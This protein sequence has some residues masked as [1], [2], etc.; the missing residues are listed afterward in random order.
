VLISGE[1]YPL[2]ETRV[3]LEE[4]VW[5]EPFAE[6][7]SSIPRSL[8]QN[9]TYYADQYRVDGIVWRLVRRVHS[10]PSKSVL[11]CFRD[12]EF[13]SAVDFRVDDLVTQGTFAS[14]KPLSFFEFRTSFR[15]WLIVHALPLGMLPPAFFGS[16]LPPHPMFY[17]IMY[18]TCRFSGDPDFDYHVLLAEYSIVHPLIQVATLDF[19]WTKYLLFRSAVI[20]AHWARLL[21]VLRF[22]A[23]LRARVEDRRAYAP[24]GEKANV[25][26]E[27]WGA[28]W[29]R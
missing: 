28:L 15:Y 13:V 8:M 25:L 29:V 9:C 27:E 23:R 18:D 1:P 5:I 6:W 20:R 14:R 16:L 2:A 19:L 21:R 7:N 22:P 10:F 12:H 11:A 24:G 17:D 3:E 4:R 26:V